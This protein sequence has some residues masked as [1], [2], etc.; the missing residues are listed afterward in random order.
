M[1]QIGREAL[2]RYFTRLDQEIGQEK[3]SAVSCWMG[4][5][6]RHGSVYGV[7]G[8]PPQGLLKCFEWELFV[9]PVSHWATN[10]P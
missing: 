8:G 3:Q 9:I 6:L 1:C 4:K 5:R 10:R 7:A 2:A